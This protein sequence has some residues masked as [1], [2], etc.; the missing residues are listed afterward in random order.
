MVIPLSIPE[1]HYYQAIIFDLNGTLIEIY[2]VSE[3]HAHLKEMAQILG[4]DK[5]TFTKAWSQT[6]KLYPFGDYATIKTR[7]LDALH[8]LYDSK[9]MPQSAQQIE[10]ACDARFRYIAGQQMKIKPGVLEILEWCLAQGYRIDIVSNCSM[11]TP[12]A[13]P[14]NPMAK[15]ISN[16]TFSSVIKI[17]KPDPGIFHYSLHKLGIE[18]PSRCIY[19]ADGDDHELDTARSLGMYPILVTYDLEDIFRHEPF[20]ENEDVLEDFWKFPDKIFDLET[21]RIKN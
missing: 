9:P 2:K 7:M 17:N 1:P 15:Y 13:W 6:W 5:D 21:K 8:I 10:D 19:V 11:E 12:L 4:I 3:Y 20:P 16:P 14:S 18:D